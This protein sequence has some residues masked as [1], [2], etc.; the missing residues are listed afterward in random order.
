MFQPHNITVRIKSGKHRGNYGETMGKL[1]GIYG[2]RRYS[3]YSPVKIWYD[4]IIS[5]NFQEWSGETCLKSYEHFS[6]SRRNV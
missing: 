2:N 1:W 6:K 4:G 3:R 5:A